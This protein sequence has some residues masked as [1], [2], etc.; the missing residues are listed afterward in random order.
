MS[1][2]M[3]HLTGTPII[4]EIGDL[5]IIAFYYLLKSGEYIKPWKVKR[6]GKLV[7]AT[8]TQQFKV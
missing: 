1:Y 7:R 3:A 2:H 8:S 5:P 4:H 6:N